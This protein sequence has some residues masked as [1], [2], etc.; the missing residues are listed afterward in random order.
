MRAT[1]SIS[2]SAL[3]VITL[4]AGSCANEKAAD[5][6]ARRAAEEEEKAQPVV[7]AAP[8]VLPP[9]PGS[10]RLPCAQVVDPAA[11]TTALGEKEPMELRDITATDADAASVCAVL[12]GGKRMTPKE[13]ERLAKK[14]NHKLGVLPGEEFCRITTYCWTI[15]TLES[16]QTR[17]KERHF[18][19]STELGTYSCVQVINQGAAALNIHQFYDEDTTCLIKVSGGPSNENNDAIAT[20]ARTARD[21]IGPAQI[22]VGGVAPA[23]APDPAPAP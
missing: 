21:T 15:D 7:K 17:C 11:Y 8:K 23:P 9:V 2:F 6:Q 19:D 4:F 20:C 14:T 22:A 18:K 13:Q 16:L 1:I 5:E 12:R 3:L 10:A